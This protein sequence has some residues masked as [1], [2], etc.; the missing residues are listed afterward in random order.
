MEHA[1]LGILIAFTISFVAIP[2]VLKV[3]LEKN[4]FDVPDHRKLHV[5]PI[6]SLGG[7]AIFCGFILAALISS[8]A[9]ISTVNNTQSQFMA[10]AFMVVF[11]TGVMDDVMEITALKKLIAQIIA[12]LILHVKL[13]LQLKGLH[14][15]FGI[16]EQ[17]PN[18]ISIVFTFFTIVVITNAFNLIDG[19]DGLAASLGILTTSCFG[20]Y[21][22]SIGEQVDA[23]WAFSMAGALLAFL[24]YNH[25]PAKIFMGDTGSLTLGLLNAYLVI[26]FIEL[27][28]APDT[29]ST[30]LKVTHAPVL[31]MAILAVPLVDTLRVFAIRI[32]KGRSPFS[33]DRNHIHHLLIDRGFSHNHITLLLVLANIVIIGGAYLLQPFLSITW[34]MVLILSISMVIVGLLYYKR[35]LYI[36]KKQAEDSKKS[37]GVLEKSDAPKIINYIRKAMIEN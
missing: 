35:E 24:I 12:A 3:A 23:V 21:F 10:A 25:H 8:S 19:I 29:Q 11:F 1:V 7:V 2:R 13:N 31:G 18:F 26:R 6:P 34:L 27:A 15:V 17:L 30:F 36:A 28:T 33:P 5:N 4:L 14:G 32:L 22:I 37:K 20:I 9:N 16:Y